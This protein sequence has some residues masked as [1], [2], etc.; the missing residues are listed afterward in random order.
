MLSCNEKCELIHDRARSTPQAEN[1]RYAV[2]LLRGK[3]QF[4]GN[5]WPEWGGALVHVRS[6]RTSDVADQ[7]VL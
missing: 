7:S 1:A 3:R 4:Q 6:M 2:P 5:D